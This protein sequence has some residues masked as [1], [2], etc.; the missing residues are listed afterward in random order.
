MP[1]YHQAQGHGQEKVRQWLGG[2]ILL[3][4][5]APCLQSPQDGKI[6]RTVVVTI[7]ES[8]KTECD[9][10]RSKSINEYNND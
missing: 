8:D 5:L 1:S 2:Q 10:C 3:D 9:Y 4:S 7:F 6:I